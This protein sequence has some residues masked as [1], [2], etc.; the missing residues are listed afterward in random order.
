[1]NAK[2]VAAV[3]VADQPPR[4]NRTLPT[5]PFRGSVGPHF[6]EM[7]T[8]RQLDG[9][10]RSRRSAQPTAPPA[11]RAARCEKRFFCY[12]ATATGVPGRKFVG[13]GQ[14]CSSAATSTS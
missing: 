6:T 5:S 3:L 12:P 14:A 10:R 13:C 9:K 4:A 7:P 2:L 1:M 11:E 8:N